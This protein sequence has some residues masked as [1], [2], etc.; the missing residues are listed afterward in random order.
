LKNSPAS[1]TRLGGFVHWYT[2]GSIDDA[3]PGEM[4]VIKMVEARGSS[5]RE[6][7]EAYDYLRP[8]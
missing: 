2:C 6:D 1:F 8:N 4:M 5:T 3:K 7:L